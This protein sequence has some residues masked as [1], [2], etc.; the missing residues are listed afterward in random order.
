MQL[1]DNSG[2]D[3]AT[4]L[5]RLRASTDALELTVYGQN[6]ILGVSSIDPEPRA[7][8]YPTD[9]VLL[10]LRQQGQ[11]VSVEPQPGGPPVLLI[12]EIDRADEPFE[13]FLLEILS[14]Y[15]VTVPETG[16]M[17]STN[18]GCPSGAGVPSRRPRRWPTVNAKAPSWRPTT[19]PDSST[20]LVRS[21][22]AA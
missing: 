11:F 13:A 4:K 16:S 18:R 19:A 17:S 20:T 2:A 8:R 3:L 10:Q 6:R 12:D 22:L 15:Q 9:E 5:N 14:D 1:A 7:P 21:Q